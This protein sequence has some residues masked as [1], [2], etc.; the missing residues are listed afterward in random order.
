MVAVLRDGQAAS[1]DDV[2][3]LGQMC[4]PGGRAAT[5]LYWQSEP[6]VRMRDMPVIMAEEMAEA[7]PVVKRRMSWRECAQRALRMH[8]L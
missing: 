8:G 1:E 5:L 7:G 2:P 4:W 6:W 3:R